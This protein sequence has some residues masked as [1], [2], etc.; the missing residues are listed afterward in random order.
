MFEARW[1]EDRT[2]TLVSLA[3]ELVALGPAVMLTATG[4]GI[5]ALQSSFM[6]P[7]RGTN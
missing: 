5:S 2:E 6:L 4:A 7:I 3:V 1:A